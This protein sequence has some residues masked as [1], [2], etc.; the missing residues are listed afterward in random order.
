MKQRPLARKLLANPAVKPV[1]LGARDTLRLEAGLHLYGQDMDADTTVM[2]A[3]LGWA[4]ARSRRAGGAKQGGFPG[5]DVYLRQARE[6]TARKLSD[7]KA[8]N[9]CRCAMARRFSIRKA[10]RWAW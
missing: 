1:G 2:E 9:R 7:W 8:R 6:G 3:S 5:A 10:G 4:I